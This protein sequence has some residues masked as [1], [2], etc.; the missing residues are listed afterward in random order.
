[1]SDKFDNMFDEEDI[2]DLERMKRDA[3]QIDIDDSIDISGDED[4]QGEEENDDNEDV[5]GHNG[6]LMSGDENKN[7]PY[8]RSMIADNT[9]TNNLI[10]SHNIDD[11]ISNWSDRKKNTNMMYIDNKDTDKTFF[12]QSDMLIR[13]DNDLKIST[14]LAP[15]PTVPNN[16]RVVEIENQ[17]NNIIKEEDNEH[18]KT[19][20]DHKLMDLNS[21]VNSKNAVD[22]DNLMNSNILPSEGLNHPNP[23]TSTDCFQSEN[24]RFSKIRD[25]FE[26]TSQSRPN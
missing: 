3:Q 8:A 2:N 16:R 4:S 25:E 1:M 17:A 21:L 26:D 23:N 7:S 24:I 18:V 19:L 14:I 22:S 15:V 10:K 13:L 12:S 6:N 20:E 11:D 5:Y 9:N